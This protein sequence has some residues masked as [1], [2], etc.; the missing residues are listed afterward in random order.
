MILAVDTLSPSPIYEQLRDQ[1]VAG[2]ASGRLAPGEALPSVRGLAADLG[3]NFHTV[4]KAYAILC[5]EGYIAMDRRKGA[6]VAR[7]TERDAAFSASL[8]RRLLLTAAEAIC[9][10]IGEGEFITL[11]ADCYRDAKGASMNGGTL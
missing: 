3:V 2:I 4:N 6:V 1:I 11:C 8:S 7:K 10:E 5:D 9:R